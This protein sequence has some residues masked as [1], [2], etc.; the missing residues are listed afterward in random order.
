M[1]PEHSGS[2]PGAGLAD[3]TPAWHRPQLGAGRQGQ[4]LQTPYRT[5]THPPEPL[6]E[7]GAV[8][9][10]AVGL[11]EP[12]CS[13]ARGLSQ[14]RR[15]EERPRGYLYPAEVW[16]GWSEAGRSRWGGRD[17]TERQEA[18]TMGTGAQPPS[19]LRAEGTRSPLSSPP[20]PSSPWGSEPGL[21]LC[22]ARR[23]DGGLQEL[24]GPGHLPR[25]LAP[26]PGASLTRDGRTQTAARLSSLGAGQAAQASGLRS[27]GG[28]GF[29]RAARPGAEGF[30][31]G[32]GQ[33]ASGEALRQFRGTA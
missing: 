18:G 19:G 33:Q 30:P 3:L 11:I 29:H 27:W 4:Q 23:R 6:E 22:D 5:P 9:C 17:S 10:T 14:G 25:S 1:Q 26:T 8:G 28:R 32:K 20:R 15:T 2:E 21:M 12:Q 13:P 24:W 7:H 31:E 16:W